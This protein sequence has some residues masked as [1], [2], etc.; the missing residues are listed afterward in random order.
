MVKSNKFDYTGRTSSGPKLG[1]S[2]ASDLEKR[3]EKKQRE[4]TKSSS[5]SAH[6]AYFKLNPSSTRTPKKERFKIKDR[7]RHEADNDP[8][9]ST[10]HKLDLKVP[11]KSLTDEG[12]ALLADSLQNALKTCQD[13]ALVDLNLSNNDLT[14]RSLARLA[15][16]ILVSCHTL[17]TLDLSQNKFRVSTPAEAEDWELFLQSFRCCMTLR[18]L[19]LSDNPS[20]GPRA[21]EILARVYSHEPP[22]EPLPAA[23]NQSFITLPDSCSALSIGSFDGAIP[24][25]AD[26]DL[27]RC[28]NGKTMADKW[29]L[30][31][32][33]GLRSLPYLTLSNVGLNDTGALFLSYIL[34]QHY[35]PIQL[36]TENNATEATSTIRTYRQDANTKGV[37][38]DNNSDFLSKDGLHLLQCAERLRMK[39][40]LGDTD[41]I[42]SSYMSASLPE[43]HETSPRKISTAHLRRP[44]IRSFQST[45]YSIYDKSDINSARKKIQRNTIVHT[46]CEGVEL[47]RASLT[48]IIA[49]RKVFLLAPVFKAFNMIKSI[50]NINDHAAEHETEAGLACASLST[51]DHLNDSLGALSLSSNAV[52]FD[53]GQGKRSYAATLMTTSPVD[54][55]YPEHAFPDAT[56]HSY[57]QSST[58]L[59]TSASSR[60][61]ERYSSDGTQVHERSAKAKVTSADFVRYQERLMK[62]LKSCHRGE[63]DGYRDVSLHCHLPLTTCLHILR[64]SMSAQQLSLLGR[65]KQRKAFAWGQKRETLSSEYDW[66][67]KDESSQL[68][69]L[70]TSAGCIEY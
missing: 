59:Q 35:Y 47:W 26:A 43:A 55:L 65:D 36:V 56:N 37:D 57:S 2:I 64:L 25:R 4:A 61:S 68:L 24:S 39:M 13:L 3:A 19:D 11:S 7:D 48:A 38:W 8:K 52:E 50:Q 63:S 42:T 14:T 46:G 22:V 18:R 54:S 16:L 34:E 1:R 17:Q 32:R 29:V 10:I 66:R 23:G 45:D 31:H 20:L 49:S 67:M 69:M 41:S 58:V 15:P 27:P 60:E 28:A 62:K 44:S 12:L 53:E 40:L 33:S 70:L 30:K 9:E 51:D 21:F 6:R 5:T